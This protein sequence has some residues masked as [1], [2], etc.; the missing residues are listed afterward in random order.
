[1]RARESERMGGEDKACVLK[2]LTYG[3]GDLL[4]WTSARTETSLVWV[5]GVGCSVLGNQG[6]K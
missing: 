1:M 6:V 2:I 5:E 3:V 4:I